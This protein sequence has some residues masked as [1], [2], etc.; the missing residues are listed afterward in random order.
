MAL[1]LTQTFADTVELLGRYCPTTRD[2]VDGPVRDALDEVFARIELAP[3][4]QDGVPWEALTTSENPMDKRI[5]QAISN[6]LKQINEH[7]RPGT[8]I[9]RIPVASPG[10]APEAIVLHAPRP[11]ATN[12]DR[13]AYLGGAIRL[14][15]ISLFP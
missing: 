8:L 2:R 6:R 14:D 11:A 7:L 10:R 3:G 15:A 1:Y 9:S 12:Q 4:H 13:V 5:V